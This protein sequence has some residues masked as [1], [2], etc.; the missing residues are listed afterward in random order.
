MRTAC[1]RAGTSPSLASGELRGVPNGDASPPAGGDLRVV[2]IRLRRR[3]SRRR[4]P[5]SRPRRQT[6]RHRRRRRWRALVSR[7]VVVAGERRGRRSSVVTVNG[8]NRPIRPH[9]AAVNMPSATALPRVRD[10]EVWFGLSHRCPDAGPTGG[11]QSG[12]SGPGCCATNQAGRVLAG[13]HWTSASKT[14]RQSA[15]PRITPTSACHCR[16]WHGPA[17]PVVSRL[18]TTAAATIPTRTAGGAT[19]VLKPTPH[20]RSSD[21][22]I[23]LS[24]FGSYWGARPPHPGP[25]SSGASFLLQWEVCGRWCRLSVVPSAVGRAVRH[26]PRLPSP[27]VQTGSTARHSRSQ[28]AQL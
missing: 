19:G 9:P 17:S 21:R 10:D 20:R 15:R 2:K 13:W 22:Q 7:H 23:T 14:A 8:A 25:P 28:Q 18:S 5:R 1:W 16:A 24:A 26:Q 6:S 4:C 12:H 11:S 27:R 3:N